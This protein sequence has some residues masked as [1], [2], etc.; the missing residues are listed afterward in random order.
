[1]FNWFRRR[2][3]SAEARRKLLIVSARSEEAIL[4][5]HV[6]N[7]LDLIRTLKGEV[8][9]ERGIDI[10]VEMMSLPEEMEAPLTNRI[11]A[12]AEAPAP[13]PGKRGRRFENVFSG[14]DQS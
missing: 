12:R 13:R 6:A 10:Y 9:L 1:M 8:D 2:R 3:L 5:T 4:E 7:V 11:L 14:E